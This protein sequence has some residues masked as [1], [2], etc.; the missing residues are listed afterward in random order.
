MI[1]VFLDADGVLNNGGGPLLLDLINN[2]KTIIQATNC[3]I[4]VS[5]DW[6]LDPNT[7][8]NPKDWKNNPPY[9]LKQVID[10]VNSIGSEVIDITP[11]FPK[12]RITQIQKWLKLNKTNLNV[13]N[14]IAFIAIDDTDL[15]TNGNPPD[16][17]I[18]TNEMLGLTDKEVV[19]A[20]WIS[21]NQKF[22]NELDHAQQKGLI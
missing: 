14:F 15:G 9:G 7:Y 22:Q 12:I 11:D 6:K 21:P 20:V 1:I 13:T 18:K 19:L 3:K 10:I 16:W 5:S 8:E 4:V 2:L 17:L